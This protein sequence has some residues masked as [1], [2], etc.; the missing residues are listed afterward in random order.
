MGKF[1]M[2]NFEENL[3]S[4]LMDLVPNN[5]IVPLRLI[6]R[7]ILDCEG[8]HQFEITETQFDI[9]N[10]H[11]ERF[12][13]MSPENWLDMVWVDEGKFLFSSY[14][15]NG[16][17]ANI[18][19]D[20]LRR[21]DSI[22]QY[23]LENGLHTLR[24]MDGHG[25]FVMCFLKVI[26][27]AGYDMNDYSIELADINEFSSRWHEIFLPTNV[28]VV[29]NNITPYISN[30]LD[31][32]KTILSHTCLYFNFCGIGD[33]VM[34]LKDFLLEV[35]NTTESSRRIFVSYSRRGSHR[36]V[37][38]KK[39]ISKLGRLVY[40]FDS[41]GEIVSNRGTFYTSILSPIQLEDFVI[42]DPNS[43]KRKK[44]EL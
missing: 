42:P 26:R 7:S 44:Y 4:N 5:S 30:I 27:D 39:L 40:W 2:S 16:D 10:T 9:L 33:S 8:S 3:E 41:I 34:D 17:R 38:R 13:N 1:S 14:T 12:E 22:F 23:M 25:R 43:R 11:A 29:E 37:R 32:D 31:T 28:R 19:E 35:L 21:A 36:K 18:I 15:R 6:L 24:T 20:Q